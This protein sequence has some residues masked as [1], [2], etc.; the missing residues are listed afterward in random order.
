MEGNKIFSEL[1]ASKS[2]SE[3]DAEIRVKVGKK[4][5]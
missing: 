5:S 3:I 4:S 1:K 2:W